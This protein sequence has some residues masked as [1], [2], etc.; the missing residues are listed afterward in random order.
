MPNITS[1]KWIHCYL[2]NIPQIHWLITLLHLVFNLI[3]SIQSVWSVLFMTMA[4]VFE[5]LTCVHAL[6]GVLSRMFPKS[7][8]T[9]TSRSGTYPHNNTPI[10][11]KTELLT[12]ISC[13]WQSLN[14]YKKTS[15]KQR[16]NRS[17]RLL[18]FLNCQ[19][20]RKNHRNQAHSIIQDKCVVGKSWFY[21]HC[22]I[23]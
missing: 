3:Q 6:F 11:I 18:L 8:Q 13:P 17:R 2:F 1:V 14:I 5:R 7:G 19:T 21:E 10:V 12:K 23:H 4:V 20:F 9:K 16:I 15:Q 22:L